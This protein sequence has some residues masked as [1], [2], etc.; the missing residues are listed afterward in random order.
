MKKFKLLL[1]VAVAAATT[2]LSCKKE[3]NSSKDNSSGTTN[4]TPALITAATWRVTYY[5][6]NGTDRTSEFSGYVFTFGGS[7]TVQ[8]IKS[9][10]TTSGTW[11]SLYES[12]EDKLILNFGS[13]LSPFDGINHDWHIL[14]KSS[15]KFRME[16]VSGG[17]GGTDY[18]TFE[19]I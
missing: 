13:A 3:D 6:D 19:K 14:E 18:L 15:A 1:I 10:T 9:G 11:Q 8:A 7:G 16:D 5:N 2:M 12:S 17:G 4:T